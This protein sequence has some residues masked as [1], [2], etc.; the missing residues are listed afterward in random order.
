MRRIYA[1]IAIAV[2]CLVMTTCKKDKEPDPPVFKFNEVEASGN[3]AKI[4][5]EYEYGGELKNLTLLYG[6]DPQLV[7]A[8][9]KDVEVDGRL[10]SVTV[11]DLESETKYYYGIECKTTY[12]LIRT[13]TESFM[14]KKTVSMAEVTTNEVTAV[15]TST[16]TSGGTVTSDGGA[17]I[18]ARGVCWSTSPYPTPEE[19]SFTEDGT[20]IGS[21]VSYIS[22]LTENTKYYVRAYATNEKGTAY[23]EQKEF[24]TLSSEGLPTVTT[25]EV[26]DITT[27][28]ATS[29]GNVTSDGNASVTAKG[30]CWST[31]PNPTVA[32]EH[33][34]DGT[35]I[36][37][38]V[39]YMTGLNH[40]TKYYVR[41]YATNRAGTAYGEQKEFTT[42]VNEE[43]P[44]V[45]TNEITGI[46][47]TTATSGGNVTSD[48]GANV[49]ARGVCWSTSQNPTISNSHTTDGNGTGSFTSSIAG[50]TANT[51]YY[52]RAYATNEKGTSY[53]EQKSF[54]TL[55]NI[56]LPTVTTT[57][58]S[59]IT[60]TTAT[61][62]GNVTDDGG[63]T[64]TARGVCWSTSQNPTISN[65]HT[66]DGNGTG[67]FTSSITGLTAN[68]TYYVRAYATN[69]KGTAYGEQR[70]FTTLQNIELLTVTTTNVSN[71]T[72][73]TA[74]S[75]GNVTSDGNAAVTARGV[76]W[77]TSQN[78][79]I[80][81]SHTTDGNGTGSF[82]SNITGL[83]ANT[84]YYVR[85][86]A[87]NS[88]GTG[89]GDEISFTTLEN[90]ELP[91]VTTT[92]VTDVTQ[93][94][95]KSGGN[96]TD[97]GGTT[98]TA[99]GV[100]WSTSQN[101]TISNSHT[102]DGNGTGSFTS[103]ITGLT[104]N[105]TYYVRAYATNSAGTGYGEQRS[106]TTLQNIELPTV[107]TTNVSNITQTTAT[108]GGNVTSDGGA[109]VT[110]RGVCWSTSQNPTIS[111]SHTTDGNGT[112]SFTS[113]ITGLT[114]NTTYYV[115]AYATNSAGTGYGDVVSF[116]T[117]EE[118]NGGIINGHEYVDLGLPSGLKWATCNVGASSPEDH[119][120][121]FAWGETT[122]KAEYTSGNSLTCGLY[123]SEL[124][125]QGIVDGNGNLT[126]S[127][128]AATANW[129]GTWRLPTKA[130][131][132]ELLHNCTWEW[133]ALNG[134]NGYKVTGPNGNHIFLPAAGY[135]NGSSLNNAGT[136][137][138]YW[139][140]TPIDSNYDDSACFLYFYDGDE[141]VDYDNR[142]YGLTVRPISE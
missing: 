125:S 68:T 59:N 7:D 27:N 38:F 135:R 30:I 48:G 139:S 132:R 62:G 57:N 64:L 140:S 19:D 12:S 78:P 114:A 124:Q 21:F 110:A 118:E 107:T 108:S 26:T 127:H 83:T 138:D 71:I 84:T 16:A 120:D 35:G 130:E 90:V 122:T 47:Q 100:C 63:A 10:F 112:G 11:D 65:S 23:G 85:A 3:S 87:T 43:L 137:G 88:A 142:R 49:T 103:S 51:T 5:G 123:I 89:Y 33:T 52:V 119:G 75:G 8:G 128:D 24:T 69:E 29:G 42:E 40:G 1:I 97:D 37:S 141:S 45:T 13:E 116:T 95:A 46:T 31:T 74:T 55:Q 20:G 54:K 72:Q 93:T 81:N 28:S 9:K 56:E 99:R 50:L 2:S 106:F 79:T 121:Y 18:T 4:T 101:P 76:C 136:Y 91:I 15:A 102:T 96:V 70:S 67:N 94:T 39:S 104:A 77:S 133:T 134:I 73:T 44:I 22:G 80:S 98:I 25:N 131:L 113:S 117:L 61:S 17:T 41:A 111:N 6:K 115:R 53:G 82:T 109:N 66:T 105:T 32:N 14:T 86:Y 129:G 60:Q 36:G 126:P 92:N 34:E 58:V